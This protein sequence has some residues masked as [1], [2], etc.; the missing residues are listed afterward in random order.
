MKLINR[1]HYLNQ[2]S[3]V[4]NTPDI[5]I[6]TGIRRSGK[7]KLLSAFARY[8]RNIDSTA[9]VIEIDLT[10]LRFEKLKEAFSD[11]IQVSGLSGAYPYSRT[12]DREKYILFT[13]HKR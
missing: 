11:Y 4:M 9:N 10:K 3:G 8:I 6:V 1:P 5:K 12:S 2:L 7:S 13:K